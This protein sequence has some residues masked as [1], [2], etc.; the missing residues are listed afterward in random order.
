MTTNT[1]LFKTM[2]DRYNDAAFTHHYIWGFAHKGIVYMAFTEADMIPFVCKLD[3]AGRGCGYSLRFCPKTEQKMLLMTKAEALCSV[4]YFNEVYSSCKY[5][6]GEVFE[7]LVTEH[8]GQEWVKDNVP[9][10]EAGDIEVNG[11]AYQIKY[12][13]ATFCNEKSL[14]NL[15]A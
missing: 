14:A 13:R 5:N 2:I 11:K 3:A 15:A 8:F 6:R 12:D 10:T 9:F 7:K 1:T 4:K